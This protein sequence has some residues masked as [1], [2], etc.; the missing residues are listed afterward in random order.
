MNVAEIFETMEYGPASEAA[1]PAIAWLDR[2]ERT[3]GHFVGGSFVPG[4][5]HFESVNPASGKPLARIAQATEADVE[6]AV[7]AARQA[8]PGWSARS[9]HERAR[10]LYA[11]ARQ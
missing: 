1:G 7:A 3:F 11:L 10:L 2:H 8:L 5:G 6:A 9:G 4:H